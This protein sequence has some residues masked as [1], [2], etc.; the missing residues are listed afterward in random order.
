MVDA[1]KHVK[2]NPHPDFKQVESSRPDWTASD[3]FEFSKTIDPSW[4]PGSGAND[5][6]AS[7][8]HNHVHGTRGYL[9][10]CSLTL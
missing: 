7:L 2:R 8:K 6:G 1:E 10:T 5:G 4:Q 9:V 3:K